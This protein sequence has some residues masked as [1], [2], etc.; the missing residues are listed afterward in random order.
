MHTASL[1]HTLSNH[2]G[3]RAALL[4]LKCFY[5]FSVH[6]YR[7]CTNRGHVDARTVQY[8]GHRC[9]IDSWVAR[10]SRYSVLQCGA[11]QCSLVGGSDASRS[12]TS[13]ILSGREIVSTSSHVVWIQSRWRAR[14]PHGALRGETLD[15]YTLPFVP[16]RN[17]PWNPYCHL[18]L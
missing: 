10:A 7:Y 15:K 3:S 5:R 6:H 1:S 11:T 17:Q 13:G 8:M 4:Y 18:T 2:V 9:I 12:R 16:L 14:L